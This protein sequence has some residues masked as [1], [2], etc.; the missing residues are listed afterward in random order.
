MQIQPDRAIN[1]AQ[2]VINK[3]QP[4]EADT[5]RK[6][7]AQEIIERAQQSSN[8]NAQSELK[9]RT[10]PNPVQLTPQLQTR[11]TLSSSTERLESLY[12]QQVQ[13]Y[14]AEKDINIDIRV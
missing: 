9:S 1:L 5:D 7:Q 6:N 10:T 4:R 3:Q 11:S 12:Q 8:S 2:Q 13:E 14:R